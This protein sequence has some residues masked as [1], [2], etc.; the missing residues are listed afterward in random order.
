MNKIQSLCKWR[1]GLIGIILLILFAV[2]SKAQTLDLQEIKQLSYKQFELQSGN[3][4]YEA[5]LFAEGGKKQVVS[6]E[7]G[8]SWAGADIGDTIVSGD[9]KIA[10]GL[11]GSNQY[12]V[13][14]LFTGDSETTLNMTRNYINVMSN[15]SQGISD[16]LT[17][18][19]PHGSSNGDLFVYTIDNRSMKKVQFLRNNKIFD[20]KEVLRGNTDEDRVEFSGLG[21]LKFKSISFNN[22]ELCGYYME[23]YRY[24]PKTIRLEQSGDAIRCLYLDQCKGYPYTK[25]YPITDKEA[26]ELIVSAYSWLQECLTAFESTVPDDNWL[27]PSIY[28]DTKSLEMALE[29]YWSK[30]YTQKLLGKYKN[31]FV[32]KAGKLYIVLGD[33]GLHY[34]LEDSE[35]IKVEDYGNKKKIFLKAR[36]EGEEIRDTITFIIVF[37]NRGWVLQDGGSDPLL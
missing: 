7:N 30:D 23:I 32:E 17:I 34:Y 5:Y 21:G 11:K 1:N 14:D 9:L 4:T 37:T 29:I 33:F 28:P 10:Y 18:Y 16:F 22:A 2:N 27:C 20:S 26:K 31:N 15:N 24:N 6:Q 13:F 8:L 35:I 3:S 19:Q 12:K 25:P 36:R